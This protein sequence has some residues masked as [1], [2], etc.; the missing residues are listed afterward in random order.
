MCTWIRV[1]VCMCE[2]VWLFRLVSI[3]FLFFLL[4]N[5]DLRFIEISHSN[6]GLFS[7]IKSTSWSATLPSRTSW[8]VKN[9]TNCLVNYHYYY[10]YIYE[11]GFTDCPFEEIT[12][13]QR[14]KYSSNYIIFFN[15]CGYRLSR[16]YILRLINL[17]KFNGFEMTTL[18][19]IQLKISQFD[20]PM[21]NYRYYI[22]I[23]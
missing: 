1:H 5:N 9:N 6:C 22:S 7:Y 19:Y 23:I 8:A 4:L 21:I 16:S 2:E 14:E 11:K 15:H 10:Q 17:H 12:F 3:F 13:A 18:S 20:E